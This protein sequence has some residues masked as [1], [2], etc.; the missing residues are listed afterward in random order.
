MKSELKEKFE[1]RRNT[2]DDFLERHLE[3]LE[4]A[5]LIIRVD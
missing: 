3:K 1:G 2:K 5:D 4:G